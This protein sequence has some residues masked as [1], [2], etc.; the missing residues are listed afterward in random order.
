VVL[1]PIWVWLLLNETAERNTLVGG[2]FILVATLWNGVSRA[3]R[4]VP[5]TAV[6]RSS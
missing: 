4:P 2:A 1:A 3:R 6:D 5:S